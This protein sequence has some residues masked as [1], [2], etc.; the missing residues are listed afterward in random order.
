VNGTVSYV[1]MGWSVNVESIAFLIPMT[2]IN[3]T[4]LFVLIVAMIIAKGSDHTFDPLKPHILLAMA[5]VYNPNEDQ[6]VGWGHTVKYQTN[7]VCNFPHTTGMSS[8]FQ[9]PTDS[10]RSHRTPP[11]WDRTPPE[12]AGVGPESAG[13]RPES[14]GV[15]TGIDILEK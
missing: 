8:T 10:G 6:P 14:A 3:L 7:K 12:S 9:C 5:A 2:I 15:V 11:E 4:S 13:V 1:V